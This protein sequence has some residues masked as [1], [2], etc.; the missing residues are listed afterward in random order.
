MLTIKPALFIWIGIVWKYDENLLI[1]LGAFIEA[2]RIPGTVF[3]LWLMLLLKI[4]Y[5]YTWI[6]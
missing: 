5:T 3:A 1:L 4:R 2:F 6:E